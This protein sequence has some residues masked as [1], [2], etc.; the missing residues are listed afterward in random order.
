MGTLDRLE[1]LLPV[2]KR[3]DVRARVDELL[4]RFQGHPHGHVDGHALAG[5]RSDC[6]GIA[7]F[8]LEPPHESRTAVGQRVDGVQLGPEALP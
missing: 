4:E 8:S 2:A 6:R 1:R 5:E 3:P 7:F